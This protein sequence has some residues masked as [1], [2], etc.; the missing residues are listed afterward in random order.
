MFLIRPLWGLF[1]SLSAQRLRYTGIMVAM[2]DAFSKDAVANP[3]L[4]GPVLQRLVTA[5]QGDAGLY[6]VALHAFLEGYIR[7]DADLEVDPKDPFPDVTKA[8]FRKHAR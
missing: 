5:S 7:A 3:E 8:W 6:V 2:S 4:L 1:R